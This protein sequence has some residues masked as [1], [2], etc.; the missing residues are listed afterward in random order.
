MGSRFYVNYGT[1]IL[2]GISAVL[3]NT[4]NRKGYLLD[5]LTFDSSVSSQV[6]DTGAAGH[7]H[8]S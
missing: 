6:Y 7:R 4:C 5:G 1:S 3:G 8:A 2:Y